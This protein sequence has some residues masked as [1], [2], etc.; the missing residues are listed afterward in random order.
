MIPIAVLGATGA[1]GQKALALIEKHPDFFVAELSASEKNVGKRYVDAAHWI[2][3]LPLPSPY[4]SLPI[5]A[6]EEIESEIILSA[7]P[8]DVAKQVERNLAMKGH[9][10]FS[11]ASAHRMDPD[12]PL[13]IPEINA[14]QMQEASLITNPNCAA[15]F[16]AL[17]IAPLRKF[18]IESISITT[19][20]AVSGAGYPGVSALDILGNHIPHIPGEE[21]KIE[22]ELRKILEISIPIMTHV[23]RVPILH[24]HTISMHLTLTSPPENVSTL[25]SEPTYVWHDIPSPRQITPDDMRV[26][27]GRLKIQGN[28][29]GMIAIGHN[30]VRGAAGATLANIETYLAKVA[31]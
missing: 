29:V 11:N 14:H 31:V 9:V 7:L 22:Q 16:A 20:Q 2:E 4:S 15:V 30:L 26:H 12:V 3:E 28:Q 27:L 23:H 5:K 25:Y 24:G 18:G 21:K 1:V 6:I 10:V 19:L 8:A 13:L 17:A